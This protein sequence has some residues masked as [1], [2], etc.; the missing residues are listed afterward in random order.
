MLSGRS[1]ISGL[2]VTYI[3]PGSA[4]D[5]YLRP[6]DVLT[7]VDGHAIADDGTVEF[8]QG[9]RTSYAYYTQHHQLGDRLT[10]GFL[11]SG[12]ARTLRIR[13]S[14]A[15]GAHDL[16]PGYRYD[17]RPSYYIYGGLVLCP[18]TLD[19]LR[20]WGKA[21]YDDAPTHLVHAY[22]SGRATRRVEEVVLII[23]VLPANLNTGY[24]DLVNQ[25]IVAVNGHTITNL[26]EL[27]ALVE[28]P[29][30]SA[31]TVFRTQDQER[32]VFDREQVKRQTR[33]ILETYDVP[34]DRSED[35]LPSRLEVSRRP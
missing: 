21:W 26:R 12:Q 10:V 18:L 6:G 29:T 25:R 19:Y 11:R 31:F 2:H 23:K 4:A 15:A 28:Q 33:Q 5:G 27:V 24:G 7:S 17:V 14:G 34:R 8:R 22:V 16:V 9:A 3:T 30:E 1:A 20:T 32:I 35:L 13:L